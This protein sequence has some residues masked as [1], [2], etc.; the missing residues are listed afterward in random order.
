MTKYRPTLWG[1]VF[2]CQNI[3]KQVYEFV[4]KLKSY[5]NTKVFLDFVATMWYY[6]E[7]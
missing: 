1:G 2:M 5:K 4:Q 3:Q 6:I 7:G